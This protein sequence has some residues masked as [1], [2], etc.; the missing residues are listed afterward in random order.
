[1]SVPTTLGSRL[2][3]AGSRGVGLRVR[4]HDFVH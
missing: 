1:M 3:R 4:A 2:G